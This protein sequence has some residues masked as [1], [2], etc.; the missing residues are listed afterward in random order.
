MT[1]DITQ[2]SEK[3]PV[4]WLGF[5]LNSLAAI[6]L[7]AL[8][9]ITCIDVIGR[10]VFNRPLTGSTE[11]TEI[12]VG[13]VVFAAFPVI[14]WRR[15]H[16]VVDIFDGF[17]TPAMEFVRNIIINSIA[18]IALFFLG[19]R[20]LL[21]G[22]RSLGYGEVTEYLAIPTGWMINFIGAM[23]WLSAFSLVTIGIYRA[24]IILQTS[25]NSL[26]PG[27]G[28]DFDSVKDSM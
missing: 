14:S 22:K 11:L 8:M 20:I 3:G 23:C 15:E 7:F 4:K 16:I 21:L 12:A 5:F 18:A 2:R 10:Y 19:Q 28:P 26:A 25:R 1:E 24:Y 13:I 6:T 9:L 27:S 17:F